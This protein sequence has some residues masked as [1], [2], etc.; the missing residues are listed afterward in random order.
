MVGRNLML[1][2]VALGAALAL[3]YVVA[4]RV[5]WVGEGDGAMRAAPFATV[6]Q[7]PLL[8]VA[9]AIA[10]WQIVQAAEARRAQAE[11]AQRLER[12]SAICDSGVRG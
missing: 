10:A 4:V 11:E 1:G 3:G 12:E 8:V 9:V 7:A 6:A 2:A 5:L